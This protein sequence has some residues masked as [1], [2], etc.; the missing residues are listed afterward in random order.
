MSNVLGIQIMLPFGKDRAFMAVLFGA[1]LINIAFAVLL[2]PRLQA[3][4]MA[5]AVLISETFVTASMLFHLQRCGL[6][7]L[8]RKFIQTQSLLGQGGNK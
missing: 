1:G 8:S 3:I 5:T 4:G 7:P 6:N 2:A